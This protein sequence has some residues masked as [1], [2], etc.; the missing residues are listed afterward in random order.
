LNFRNPPSPEALGKAG[1]G[2]HA[3][4]LAEDAGPEAIAEWLG[5]AHAPGLASWDVYD[6]VL[7]PGELILQ[8]SWRD[9]DAAEA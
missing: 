8:T 1:C 7:T 3:A 4:E 5:L 6:V 2:P 9:P